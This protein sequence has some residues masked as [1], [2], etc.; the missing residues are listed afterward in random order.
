MMMLRVIN[1]HIWQK[2]QGKH[3]LN[4]IYEVLMFH[5]S[6]FGFSGAHLLPCGVA[7][8]KE[9]VSPPCLLTTPCGRNRSSYPPTVSATKDRFVCCLFTT[10][11]NH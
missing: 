4:Q 10:V 7:G 9:V 11:T 1:I 6:E 3:S 2:T 8:D 5:D